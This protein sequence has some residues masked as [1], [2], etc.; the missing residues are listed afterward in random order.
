MTEMKKPLDIYISGPMR[1][2]KDLNAEKFNEMYTR[3]T[4]PNFYVAGHLVHDV[5][6]PAETQ[7]S[8]VRAAL[9]YHADNPVL[10]EDYLRYDMQVLSRQN[11]IVLLDG[12]EQSEGSRFEVSIGLT[13]GFIFFD[14]EL[15]LFSYEHLRRMMAGNSPGDKEQYPTGAWRDRRKGKGRYDL[16]SPWMLARL[17]QVLEKGAEKYGDR[18]WEKGMPM[19]R[20]F[21]SACR[22]LNQYLRDSLEPDLVTVERDEHLDDHLAQA[23]FNIMAMIHQE[24]LYDTYPEEFYD[25]GK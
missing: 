1:N 4:Q 17:A 20:F 10:P 5:F 15:D 19:S 16:I 18:N 9:G 7:D 22:H 24:E 8:L 14:S 23:L 6:N 25:L 11:C 21:D 2:C 13:L 3:L 12:W